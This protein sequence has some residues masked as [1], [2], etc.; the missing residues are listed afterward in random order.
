LKPPTS[1]G[2]LEKRVR[3]ALATGELDVSKLDIDRFAWWQRTIK[4]VIDWLLALTL[5]VLLA[6]MLLI[7]AWLIRRQTGHSAIFKQARVGYLGR[8]FTMYKFRTMRADTDPYAPAPERPD[9]PRVTAIGRWLRK[10]SLDE[11]P[12]LFNILRGEMSF[13]GPRPEMP[14]IV[15]QYE[16]WQ[17]KRLEAKKTSSTTSTTSSIARCGWT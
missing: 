9:D 1:I 15:E 13:V 16:P 3:E 8:M 14:F 10:Y 7:V 12:Q 4:Q 2:K 6:P 11:A 5:L 17:R